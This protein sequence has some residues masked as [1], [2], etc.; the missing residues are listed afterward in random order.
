MLLVHIL[1]PYIYNAPPLISPKT[2]ISI[3]TDVCQ[4]TKGEDIVPQFERNETHI[5]C[6]VGDGH[7]GPGCKNILDANSSTILNRLLSTGLEDA[8]QLCMDTCADERSGAM[9]VLALYTIAERKMQIIS[10]GDASCTIYQNNRI[11]HAQPHHD[12]ATV[13]DSS[14]LMQDIENKNFKIDTTDRPTM[15]PDKDGLTMSVELKPGYFKWAALGRNIAAASFVGHYGMGRLDPFITEYVVPEGDFHMVMTSDGVSDMIHSEDELLTTIGVTATDIVQDSKKRW[16]TPYFKE[17]DFKEVDVKGVDVEG[18]K[19]LNQDGFF[20]FNSYETTSS[21]YG[22]CNGRQMR[23]KEVL[24]KQAQT[25]T[26]RFINNVTQEL[27]NSSIHTI[28]HNQGG[29]D[30]SVLVMTCK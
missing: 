7:S 19:D 6:M 23:I 22:L 29:D 28:E 18:L 13:S 20:V 10:V 2:S 4:L 1:P 16:T 30:I 3:S 11:L 12:C 9:V 5:A 21:Q 24:N 8:M 17:V 14:E 27:Q 26:V 25:S 15:I